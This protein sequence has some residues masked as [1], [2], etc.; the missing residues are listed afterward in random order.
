MNNP[1]KFLPAILTLAKQ[2]GDA[3][4]KLYQQT[5]PLEVNIKLDKTPV[6]EADLIAHQIIEQGL[7]QLTPN[8]PVLSEESANIPFD[9]RQSWSTYWLVDPLDGTKEFI[10]KTDEFT[11]N[12]ALISENK[13]ILGV[14]YSPVLDHFYFAAQGF[15][16][17]KQI[18][19]QTPIKIHTRKIQKTP[20]L[21]VSRRHGGKIVEVF[22][23]Q[24]VNY[25]LIQKGSSLKSC[26]V[27]EGIADAYPCMGPTSE[28]DMGAAQCIVE[29][30]GGAMLNL[31]G[32]P[33]RYNTKASLLNPPLLIVGDPQSTCYQFMFGFASER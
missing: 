6:T 14:I 25:E 24:L 27:A 33:L 22:L 30:A 17:F 4:L 12:I 2:A 28:W 16:A 29:E 31:S 3:I 19:Q 23:E 32:D 11:V 26:M 18:S 7:N 5:N 13:S 15:G 1:E 9:Q 20:V 10:H 8:I 21:A